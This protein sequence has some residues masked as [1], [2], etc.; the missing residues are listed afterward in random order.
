MSRPRAATTGRRHWLSRR[1]TNKGADVAH[2]D[3]QAFGWYSIATLAQVPDAEAH[4][5]AAA[6]RLKQSDVDDLIREVE[7]C[8]RNRRCDFD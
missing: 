6:A 1:C 5:G 3:R 4:R 8:Y 2:S 7:R